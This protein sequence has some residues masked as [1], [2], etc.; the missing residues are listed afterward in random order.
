VYVLVGRCSGGLLHGHGFDVSIYVNMAYFGPLH[1]VTEPKFTF[2]SRVFLIRSNQPP[3]PD[4]QSLNRHD[5]LMMERINKSPFH[6][7]LY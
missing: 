3:V 4:C 6:K 5:T 2:L 7:K 1:G